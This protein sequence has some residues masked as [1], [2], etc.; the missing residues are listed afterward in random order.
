VQGWDDESNAHY[1][2]VKVLG[3]ATDDQRA[4][5]MREAFTP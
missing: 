1:L 2:N 5:M 4:Q 3:K